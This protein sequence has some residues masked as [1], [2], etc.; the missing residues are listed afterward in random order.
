MEGWIKCAVLTSIKEYFKLKWGNF[1]IIGR[2]IPSMNCCSNPF[3]ECPPGKCHCTPNHCS[4]DMRGLLQFTLLW[5]IDLDESSG[6]E[7]AEK[8]QRRRGYKPSPGTL[9]PAL[10]ALSAKGLI[11]STKRGRSIIYRLTPQGKQGL[12]NS[13]LY[14][15]KSFG[16]IF[17]KYQPILDEMQN[18]MS[19]H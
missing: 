17:L 8:I 19:H 15:V 4:C 18:N 1:Y 6:I 14:F 3:C 5:E 10:K 7:L 12:N 2:P 13:C 11:E 16:D 9:Y